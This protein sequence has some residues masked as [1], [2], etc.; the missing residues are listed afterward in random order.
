VSQNEFL[1]DQ[2]EINITLSN[3]CAEIYKTLEE[4]SKT[5]E[6]QNKQ[7]EILK[8]SLRHVY[9]LL[10]MLGNGLCS[11]IHKALYQKIAT[12][13]I[14]KLPQNEKDLIKLTQ[15]MGLESFAKAQEKISELINTTDDIVQKEKYKLHLRELEGMFN[16]IST[17][18]ENSSEEYKVQ[19]ANELKES[20]MKVSRL[21]EEDL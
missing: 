15:E 13:S 3:Y 5:F 11:P 19:V 17:V 9:L 14:D 10:D 1:K 6:K 12:L 8:E 21:F 18:D 4:I 7:L 2:T 20:M 16:L